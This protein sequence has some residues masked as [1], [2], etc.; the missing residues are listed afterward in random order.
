MQ[1]WLNFLPMVG[2][3]LNLSAAL[4]NLVIAITNRDAPSDRVGSDTAH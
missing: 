4:T 1:Q 2:A 3:L